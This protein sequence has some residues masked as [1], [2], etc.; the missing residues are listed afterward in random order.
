VLTWRRLVHAGQVDVEG[1]AGLRLSRLSLPE[2]PR[3]CCEVD[4][5]G[6]VAV[7]LARF[8]LAGAEV[9][10]LGRC[11]CRGRCRGRLRGGAV[12][13]EPCGE[14]LVGVV[15]LRREGLDQG[16]LNGA[17]LHT[18]TESETQ[19][20]RQAEAGRQAERER[21]RERERETSLCFATYASVIGNRAAY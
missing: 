12:R 15:R 7:S 16:L 1:V 4:G 3:L 14:G 2:L 21:E 10:V 9:L 11:R 8:L 20:G 17:G 13:L 18:R 19:T 5:D 6:T